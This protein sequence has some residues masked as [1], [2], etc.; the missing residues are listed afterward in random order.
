MRREMQQVTENANNARLREQMRN[1]ISERNKRADRLFEKW[2]KTPVI[3]EG[4]RNL[5]DLN[6]S[7]ARNLAFILENEEE[8]LSKLTETQISSSFQTTPENV[9]R[10]VRYAYPNSIRGEV[11]LEWGMETARDSIYYLHSNYGK[12]LRDATKGAHVLETAEYRYPTEVEREAMDQTADG[13]QKAFTHTTAIH[14]FRPYTVRILVN[15]SPVG[16]DDGNGNFHGNGV[17]GTVNYDSGVVEFTFT[18]APANGTPIEVEYNYDSEVDTNYGN[19]GSIELQIK[20]YQFIVKPKPLYISWSKMTELL[21][22]TTLNIDAEEALIRGAADEFKKALDFE[23]VSLGWRVAKSHTPVI[24]DCKGAVGEPEVDRMNAFSKAVESAGD[25]MLDTI[26]RGGVTKMVGGPKAVT[27]IMLHSRFDASNRQPKV[28]IYRVG[29]LDGV[30]IYKAPSQIIPNDQIMCVYRNELIP[31][32][33]AIA[34]GTLVPLYKTQTLE[35]KEFYKETGMA[36]FGDSKVL[37]PLYL[38]RIQLN[39]MV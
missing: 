27:Q 4:L 3:G 18:T 29:S 32:D 25:I 33:V 6:E 37:Q 1:N 31:E 35:F 17:S 39:N 22:N 2:E 12:T 7:K 9:V 26:M 36:I 34:F 38:Q 5:R 24:F 16:V 30:D 8:H 14:P 15:G 20:D 21:L 13:S 19:I 10:I 28:G 11:F 23:A